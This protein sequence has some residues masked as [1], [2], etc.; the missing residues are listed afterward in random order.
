[1]KKKEKKLPLGVVNF[2]GE[3]PVS[4]IQIFQLL[5]L[6]DLQKKNKN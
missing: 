2:N 3:F 4:K 1:M 6:K 5:P